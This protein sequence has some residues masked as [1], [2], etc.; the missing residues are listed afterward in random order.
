MNELT[1]FEPE[2]NIRMKILKLMR[3]MNDGILKSNWEHEEMYEGLI[4]IYCIAG[5]KHIVNGAYASV[6][7]IGP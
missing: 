7:L 3:I 1:S 2:F 6:N 4:F 5:N